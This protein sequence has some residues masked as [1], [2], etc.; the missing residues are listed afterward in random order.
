MV[1]VFSCDSLQFHLFSLLPGSRY[2]DK[3]KESYGPGSYMGPPCEPTRLPNR[4]WAYPPRPNNHR[5]SLPFRP[6]SGGPIPVGMRGVYMSVGSFSERSSRSCPC[7]E[8]VFAFRVCFMSCSLNVI[9]VQII[10]QK[11]PCC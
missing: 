8:C 9:E 3:H 10:D 11:L 6:P 7:A 5:N 1:L 2:P 4:E